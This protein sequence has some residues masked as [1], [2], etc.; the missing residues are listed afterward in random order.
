MPK[1][2]SGKVSAIS[3][4][5]GKPLGR[6]A[7][8]HLLSAIETGRLK[9]GDRISV[10]AL[11]ET[12]NISRTPVREAVAL[13]EGDGLIVHEPHRGRVVSKLDHQMVNELYAIRIVL[14]ATGAA[15]AARNASDA[16]ID[17]LRDML[18]AEQSVLSDPVRRE[19]HNRRFHEA[20]FRSAHNRYLIN[21]LNA[22]Q[23][24]MLLL[25]PAT[26]SDPERLE[27]A[28]REHIA[29]VAAIAEHDPDQ[30]KAVIIQHLTAGQRARIKHMLQALDAD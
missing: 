16:E 11:S 23:T 20:V 29:L 7:Y 12:M 2:P 14:E 28:Y 5:D 4:S 19:R 9:P 26:A 3:D 24:P 13:L 17:I 25:G 10:N 30:A 18:A 8:E 22:L 1:A 21:T 15:L 6:V 27:Q